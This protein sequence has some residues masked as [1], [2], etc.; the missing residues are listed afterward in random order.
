VA[1]GTPL[2]T[3]LAWLGHAHQSELGCFQDAFD[4]GSAN[5]ASANHGQR[6]LVHGL[7]CVGVIWFSGASILIFGNKFNS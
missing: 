2:A 3:E 5:H 6:E 1:F 4:V 7:F